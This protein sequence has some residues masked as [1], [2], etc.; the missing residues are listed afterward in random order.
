MSGQAEHLSRPAEPTRPAR[1]SAV[2][3]SSTEQ[4]L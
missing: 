4:M 2:A 3:L 1:P